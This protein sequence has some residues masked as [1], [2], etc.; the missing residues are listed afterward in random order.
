[1]VI[2]AVPLA[3]GV[4]ARSQVQVRHAG[5]RADAGL[6]RARRQFRRAHRHQLALGKQQHALRSRPQSVPVI[7]RAIEGLV[8]ELEGQRAHRQAD[9]DVAVFPLEV[10]Q[11]RD[12]PGRGQGG[13]DG[14]VDAAAHA[15]A[16]DQAEGVFFDLV[17]VV[18]DAAGVFRPVVGQH[19]APPHPGEQ[20]HAQARLQAGHLAVDRAVGQGQFL[21]RARKAAQAGGGFERLQGAQVGNAV[22]HGGSCRWVN[23]LCNFINC[24]VRSRNIMLGC[25]NLGSS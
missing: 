9:G 12:Q 4:G 2:G 19:D 18:A 23:R 25:P 10:R 16:A 21:G 17:Q 15:G 3:P 22:S 1:M 8:L 14:D 24:I 20:L 13:H 7:Q 11:A 6:R 5:Q